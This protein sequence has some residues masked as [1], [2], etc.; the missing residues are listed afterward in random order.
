MSSTTG[1]T[2]SS[3]KLS[4]LS[5]AELR[6]RARRIG[7]RWSSEELPTG[8]A[9]TTEEQPS[10]VQ[11]DSDGDL[12]RRAEQPDVEE[13]LAIEPPATEELPNV[14]NK[15]Q[16]LPTASVTTTAASPLTLF[17]AVEQS[18]KAADGTFAVVSEE[19][20]DPASSILVPDSEKINALEE[21]T[22]TEGLER[23]PTS[24]QV[25]SWRF[26]RKPRKDEEEFRAAASAIPTTPNDIWG[27]LMSP[28]ATVKE[29]CSSMEAGRE[30]KMASPGNNSKDASANEV[31]EAG[32]LPLSSKGEL[33]SS[34]PLEYEPSSENEM[35]LGLA[36]RGLVFSLPPGEDSKKVGGALGEKN[37]KTRPQSGWHSC[38]L[39]SRSPSRIEE[40]KEEQGRR[41]SSL[42]VTPN[43]K[44]TV[45]ELTSKRAP[46]LEPPSEYVAELKS[47]AR[48]G[49]PPCQ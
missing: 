47:T 45:E 38:R 19:E 4:N 8:N 23:R 22:Q 11:V 48:S 21:E 49:G 1:S 37:S 9:T 43:T 28:L 42:A 32:F 34:K 35:D 3:S 20:G 41:G 12:E 14:T 44:P 29:I 36:F 17:A 16:Q 39:V 24:G 6:D 33:Q 31:D 13:V 5:W 15:Q 26:R 10:V 30:T 25:A 2:M 7:R 40:E 18:S 27:S 46:E